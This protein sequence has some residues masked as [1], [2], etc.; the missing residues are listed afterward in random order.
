MVS[1]RGRVT[2]VLRRGLGRP[3]HHRSASSKPATSCSGCGHPDDV[4]PGSRPHHSAC[5]ICI[6][7][8]D[9]GLRPE[10]ACCQRPGVARSSPRI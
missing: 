10:Q 7:E 1:K 3:V 9:M 2:D 8:V 5:A 6:W 4:H